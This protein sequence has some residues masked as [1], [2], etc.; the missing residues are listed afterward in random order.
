M[1]ILLYIYLDVIIYCLLVAMA[2]SSY[3]FILKGRSSP[4]NNENS[5]SVLGNQTA[6]D[7]VRISTVSN[8]STTSSGNKPV[9]NIVDNFIR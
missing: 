8:R 1:Y 3:C 2:Y 6:V 7:I 9:P 5:A 4:D